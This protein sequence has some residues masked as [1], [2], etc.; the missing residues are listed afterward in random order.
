MT[1]VPPRVSRLA[2]VAFCAVIVVFVAPVPAHAQGDEIRLALLPVGQAGSFF[3]LTMRPGERRSLAVDIANNGEAPLLARTYAA[4]V[5]TIINGGFGA[6]LRDEAQ[7]GTTMWLEY[8][9][10]LLQLPVGGGIRRSFSVAVPPGA[11]PGEYIT[12]L[13]LEN[14]EPFLQ[15]G[16]LTLNQVV[17]QAVAVVI[18]VPGK[19]SPG[20]GIGAAGHKVVAGVSVVAVA[21]QNTGNIRLKPFVTFALSNA[22]GTLVSKATVPMDAFY[23]KT[24]TFVEVPLAVLLPGGTYTVKLTAKDSAQGLPMIE[25]AIP[26]RVEATPDDPNG[27]GVEQGGTLIFNEGGMPL[28]GWVAI[29]LAA[30]LLAVIAVSIVRARRRVAGAHA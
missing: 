5:Y 14:E 3:D 30:L 4:D 12:S 25:R 1:S 24:A 2:R 16:A 19:R 10:D 6:R 21:V 11:V 9:T 17:R 27:G 13:V 7:S 8:P 20:L 22:A 29:T 26:L 15:P 23:A 28:A 18:T